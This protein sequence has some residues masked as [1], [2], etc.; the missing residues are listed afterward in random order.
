MLVPNAGQVESDWLS[1]GQVTMPSP[2]SYIQGWDLLIE[3]WLQGREWLLSEKG[4]AERRSTRRVVSVTV[5]RWP[6]LAYWS[7]R[8]SSS[9]QGGKAGGEGSPL[10]PWLPSLPFMQLLG[11]LGTNSLQ[12][13]YQPEFIKGIPNCMSNASQECLRV[14]ILKILLFMRKFYMLTFSKSQWEEQ[15]PQT[16]ESTLAVLIRSWCFININFLP[17]SQP[18]RFFLQVLYCL[19]TSCFSFWFNFFLEFFLHFLR[20]SPKSP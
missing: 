1:M 10:V 11:A 9:L 12:P 3:I 17:A 5:F 19:P 8:P 7:H 2:I 20:N 4:D 15:F 14:E 13:N 18:G 6:E 16:S